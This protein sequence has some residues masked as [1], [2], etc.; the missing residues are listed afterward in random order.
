MPDRDQTQINY[1]FAATALSVGMSLGVA[2][3]HAF[4]QMDSLL[5]NTGVES[6]PVD[7]AETGDH[8]HF[9][10]K[11]E[12]KLD[13]LAFRDK[14]HTYDALESVLDASNRMGRLFDNV[15]DEAIPLALDLVD[16]IETRMAKRRALE[17]LFTRW[18][19][20]EPTTAL[21]TAGTLEN[22]M[23]REVAQRAVL[24]VWLK[25]DSLSAR[26][27]IIQSPESR[28]RER[29]LRFAV[30]NLSEVSPEQAADLLLASKDP[31][32]M[33]RRLSKLGNDW[34][35]VDP[36]AALR[37]ADEHLGE[38]E[39]RSRFVA[40]VVHGWALERPI[41]ALEHVRELT[42]LEN[43]KSLELLVEVLRGWATE[44]PT[45]AISYI[46][47]FDSE[48]E[49]LSLIQAI[50]EPLSSADPEVILGWTTTFGSMEKEVVLAQLIGHKLSDDPAAAAKLAGQLPVSNL[51]ATV[52]GD[53]AQSWAQY[54]APAASEWLKSLP[55]SPAR[56][57]AAI[58][59]ANT[60]FESDNGVA[61]DWAMS[62]ADTQRRSDTLTALLE[63]WLLSNPG[64]AER[65][66]ADHSEDL[67]R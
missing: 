58:T 54:D 39:D 30:G 8:A 23:S 19:E 22:R 62:I 43:E 48:A 47:R 29:L 27:Y 67:N 42:T 61:L 37:W 7:M 50:S 24:A 25:A 16:D 3:S 26:Q 56:D 20:I 6:D 40:E 51:Q 35:Q 9:S 59:F 17:V 49:Q 33:S 10:Y 60:I 21:D 52:F 14:I 55:P 5:L 66:L 31:T 13:I 46:F 57:S 32:M 53:L 1:V 2:L 45:A 41:E 65:W 63:R 28:S 12:S 34:G 15:P 4:W 18:A 36:T 38:V 11:A 44:D 64:A